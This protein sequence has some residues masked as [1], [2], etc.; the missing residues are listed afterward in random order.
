MHRHVFELLARHGAPLLFVTQAFGIFGLPI[1]SELLLTI[2]GALVRRGVLNG[3]ATM[4]AA[5]GGSLTGITM[6]YALGLMFGPRLLKH[7]SR[8]N[9][10]SLNRGQAWFKDSGK[11]LLALSCF[12]PG[13]RH[14]APIIAG[15]ASLEFRVFA[16]FAYPGAALWCTSFVAAG[17][18]ASDRWERAAIL[19][20]G[21]AIVVSIVFVVLA[22]GYVYLRRQSRFERRDP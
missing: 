13:L 8:L 7:F 5:V 3:S 11:W 17:Y 16:A 14:I 10:T 12:V 1:P 20:R 22:I 18:Y 6:S 19:I 4:A 21:H 2:A 15:S 9:A